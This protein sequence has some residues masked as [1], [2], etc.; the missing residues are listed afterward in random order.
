M[1]ESYREGVANHPGPEPCEG[2]RKAALEALDRGICRPRRVWGPEGTPKADGRQRPLGIAALEEKIV[3]YAVGTVLNQ[4]WEEDFL[5]FS[6]GFR[7]GRGQPGSALVSD[8]S[9]AI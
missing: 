6:Y 1:K 7:S 9:S 2:S 3:Q 4:I 8:G 5:G